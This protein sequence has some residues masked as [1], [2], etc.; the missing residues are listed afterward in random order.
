MRSV[1][2]VWLGHD[3]YLGENTEAIQRAIVSSVQELPLLRVEA[4][5][6]G[7]TESQAVSQVRRLLREEDCCGALIVLA[8]WVE[9]HVVMAALK[10]LRGL[11]CMFWGFPLEEVEGR[12][13]STGAYVSATMFA[14]VVKRLGLPCPTLFASWKDPEA[15]KKIAGFARAA[16]AVDALFYAKIGLFGYTSMSIYTGTFDHV[17]MRYKIGPEIEQMDSYSLICAAEA[18]SDQERQ[19]AIER[20]QALAC[21]GPNL[22]PELMRKTMGLYVAL[23]S[24][25][26]QRGWA[27]VNVKC[28]YELSKEYQAVPC[29]ALSLLA[30]DGV[31]TSCEG[32]IPVTVTMLLLSAVSRQMVWY[33]D[34]LTHWGNTLQFSPCGFLPFSLALGETKIL[35]FQ[36]LPG[37]HGL[38]VCGVLR[39]E[40]ITWA[41]LV[42]DVGSYH[43]LY[44]TGTGVETEPRGGHMPA[45]NVELDG[46]IMKLCEEYAG[47]HF[48][49]AYGDWSEELALFAAFMGIEARRI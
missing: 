22:P 10:E 36:N 14:G 23:R 20:L 27:A 28:Q 8:T 29:V 48:A 33:G 12:K 7:T 30:E 9:C 1:G 26:R 40:R 24:F 6:I 34:S 47:Q 2:V 17:L 42:E 46:D 43:L 15:G 41:R 32:D 3:D 5:T 37:F 35:A 18:A 49:V 25:C 39:P 19:E 16:S 13:Q 21:C 44:G 38:Q 31:I 11:P 4:G 45:L